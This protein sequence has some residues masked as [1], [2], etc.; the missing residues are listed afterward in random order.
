MMAYAQELF[1]YGSC[2]F[3]PMSIW[4]EE[5]YIWW[6]KAAFFIPLPLPDIKYSVQLVWAH[7]SL[8]CLTL[9]IHL[10]LCLVGSTSSDLK[11]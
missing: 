6:N 10:N 11:V 4:K 8:A 5:L 1:S 3:F 2:F 7:S 9:L